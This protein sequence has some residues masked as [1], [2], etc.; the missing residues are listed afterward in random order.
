MRRF[1]LAW[2]LEG[3]QRSATSR[4]GAAAARAPAAGALRRCRGPAPAIAW[5]PQSES[6][7]GARPEPSLD[8]PRRTET[9]SGPAGAECGRAGAVARRS[10]RA[11]EARQRDERG[12]TSPAEQQSR[13]DDGLARRQSDGE[14]HEGAPSEREEPHRVSSVDEQPR[15]VR[16]RRRAH[17]GGVQVAHL[18]ALSV[19]APG[20]GRVHRHL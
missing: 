3:R 9:P 5:A 14:R 11:E 12:S 17:R 2:R 18:Q 4:R 15:C 7:S 16:R 10:S 13:P 6:E 19:G 20:R 8:R 1:R